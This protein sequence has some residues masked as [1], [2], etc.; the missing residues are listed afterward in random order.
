MQVRTGTRTLSELFHV[1]RNYFTKAEWAAIR[2]PAPDERAMEAAF[3]KRWSLKEAY[4]KAR[5]DGIAFELGKCEFAEVRQSGGGAVETAAITVEG[6]PKPAW[7]FF[8][9]AAP[10]EHWISVGRGPPVD[11]VDAWGGFTATFGRPRLTAAE[12]AAQLEHAEPPFEWRRVRE[13]V[14]P[15]LRPEYDSASARGISEAEQ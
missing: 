5:G 13:L 14:P 1:M 4:V 9:Q 11:A 6:A 7:R 2:E 15:E 10:E 12:L 3:R 8:L